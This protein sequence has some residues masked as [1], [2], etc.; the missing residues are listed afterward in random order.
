MRTIDS[1]IFTQ[2]IDQ[3][4]ES[5]DE[6]AGNEMEKD[7]EHNLKLISSIDSFID[8]ENEKEIKYKVPHEI[9]EL[10]MITIPRQEV[11]PVLSTISFSMIS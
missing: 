5:S 6:S 4:Y 1:I 8:A 9:N 3:I 11:L 10:P 2:P 7:H